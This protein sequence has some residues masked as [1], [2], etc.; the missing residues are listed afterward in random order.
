MKTTIQAVRHSIGCPAKQSTVRAGGGAEGKCVLSSF[1][2]AGG[3]GRECR[4]TKTS[5]PSSLGTI[6]IIIIYHRHDHD[7]HKGENRKVGVN[8]C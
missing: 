3:F 4:R 2:D 8:L 6:I 1:C 5:P 7:Y